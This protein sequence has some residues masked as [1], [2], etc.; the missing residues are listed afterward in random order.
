MIK[1]SIHKKTTNKAIQVW[2]LLIKELLGYK[3]SVCNAAD[4][5]IK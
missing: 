3:N 5:A 4:F 1:W 2:S